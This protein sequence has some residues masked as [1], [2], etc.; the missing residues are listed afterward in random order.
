MPHSSVSKS[1]LQAET[2]VNEEEMKAEHDRLLW[3]FVFSSGMIASIVAIAT[4]FAH[5]V[6]PMH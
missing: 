6:P 4:A 5:W 2:Q 1:T 3:R